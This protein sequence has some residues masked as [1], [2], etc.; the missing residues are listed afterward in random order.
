MPRARA[1]RPKMPPAEAPQPYN[2]ADKESAGSLHQSNAVA[3]SSE[4]HVTPHTNVTN[5]PEYKSEPLGQNAMWPSQIAH[6]QSTMWL[7]P[8]QTDQSS[9]IALLLRT[10]IQSHAI[11]REMLHQT[12]QCRIQSAQRIVYLETECRN[13]S[14]A[15]ENLASTLS[16]CS[17][18]IQRVSLENVSLKTQRDAQVLESPEHYSPA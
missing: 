13:W 18:E 17:E 16:K 6:Q 11:T 10:E 8:P 14:T 5:R 7:L 12:E 9:A 15:Y 1:L 3:Y 4:E 2:L